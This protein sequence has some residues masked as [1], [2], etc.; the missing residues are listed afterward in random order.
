MT[1]PPHSIPLSEVDRTLAE[2]FRDSFAEDPVGVG[3]WCAQGGHDVDQLMVEI[4]EMYPRKK[5]CPV[6]S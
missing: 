5:K 6:A 4:D 3:D 2:F 1:K